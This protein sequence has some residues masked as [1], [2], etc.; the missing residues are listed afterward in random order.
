[1]YDPDEMRLGENI[2]VDFVEERGA[3]VAVR[4]CGQ[5]RGAIKI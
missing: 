2:A 5:H 3:V 4:N 1:M